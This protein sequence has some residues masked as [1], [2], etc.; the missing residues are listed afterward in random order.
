MNQSRPSDLNTMLEYLLIST[1]VASSL[2][3]S[4]ATIGRFEPEAIAERSQTNNNPLYA[5]WEDPSEILYRFDTDFTYSRTERQLIEY[6]MSL[7]TFD[8]ESC[9]RFDRPMEPYCAYGTGSS[10][11]C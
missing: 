5:K 1:L 11:H 7:I 9:I 6:A 3:C 8:M 4:A 10:R 2:F